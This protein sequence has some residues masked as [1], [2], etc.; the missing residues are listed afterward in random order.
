[1]PTPFEILSDP[2][3]IATFAIYL[4]L[5]AWEQ[6]VPAER[7]PQ[8]QA[9][10]LRGLISFVI[11][12]YISSYLPL[13]WGAWL[14]PAQLFDLSR[15]HPAV[16]A[17]AGLLL[18]EFGLYW[19]HRAM[20][21][22]DL[23]WRIFHQMH[24]SAERVD[25]F[26]AFYFSPMDMIGFTALSSLVLVVLGLTPQAAT[27]VILATTFLSIFQHTNIRTPLWLGYLIQ[28]PESHSVHHAR[29]V[30]ASNYSDLPVFDILF[31]TF[32]NPKL[33]QREA[34]FYEGASE[35]I[36]DMV[37]FKDINHVTVRGRDG[38]TLPST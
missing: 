21:E 10:P 35:R 23:L 7:L 5:I 28:R 9:W 2:I 36:L 3:S 18:F 34:G 11:Y 24:H 4:G 17:L 29:G 12:F 25:T 32:R 38:R 6:L 31:G 37:C 16:A 20:H 27:A 1:M 22:T 14:A 13:M 19:W 26:G 33:R 15:V 8:V 30:H